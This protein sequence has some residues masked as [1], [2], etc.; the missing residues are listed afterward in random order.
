LNGSAGVDGQN[1]YR[2]SGSI[3]SRDLSIASSGTKLSDVSLST[4]F[5]ITPS[6][7]SLD[8]LR[9]A[10]LGGNISARV[11]VINGNKLSADGQIHK[12][13]VSALCSAL[14]GRSVNYG[15]A[16]SGR[17]AAMDDFQTKARSGVNATTHLSITPNRRGIPLNGIIDASYNGDSGLVD[18]Q[19]S[20]I[21]FPSSRVS[22][23][24]V[25][26]R[27]LNVSLVSRNLNDFLPLTSFPKSG[28][29][30]IRGG[31]SKL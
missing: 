9:L 3:D 4:P 15:A 19:S 8:S 21:A 13:S 5:Q 12:I 7:I 23:K 31:K 30:E 6:L 11:S 10:L 1:H 14:A 26:N 24:G 17:F 20:Y 22:A 16:I 27:A 2:A 18:L 28:R 29:Q 25:L